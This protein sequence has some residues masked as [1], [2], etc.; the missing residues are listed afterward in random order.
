M[1]QTDQLLHGPTARI[2]NAGFID[3][4]LRQLSGRVIQPYIDVNGYVELALASF[5]DFVDV[6]WPENSNVIP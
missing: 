2:G 4:A 6:V 1:P 3:L 5:G